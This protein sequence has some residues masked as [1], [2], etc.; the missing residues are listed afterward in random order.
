MPSNRTKEEENLNCFYIKIPTSA[1]FVPVLLA[2]VESYA[3]QSQFTRDDIHNI[4]LSV[5]EAIA[6]IIKHAYKHD[7]GFITGELSFA[8]NMLR[9]SLIHQGTPFD[10]SRYSEPDIKRYIKERKKGGFGIYLMKNLMDNILYTSKNGVH[11]I[12]LIKEKK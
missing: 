6:N 3:D 5:D 8:G 4:R 11:K 9:I 7:S 10:L 2:L 12:I 1:R